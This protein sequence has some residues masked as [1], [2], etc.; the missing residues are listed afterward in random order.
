MAD[1]PMTDER[2]AEIRARLVTLNP[3]V[4]E[5]DAGFTSHIWNGSEIIAADVLERNAPFLV[6]APDDM[7]TLLAEV[8]RLRT[9]ESVLQD[10][11]NGL[12][13]GMMLSLEPGLPTLIAENEAAMRIV[14]E[15]AAKGVTIYS[16]DG[17]PE[18]SIAPE[19]IDKARAL[20]AQE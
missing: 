10:E 20:L 6:H 18:A 8:D 15:V 7:R 11:V 14:R 12:R 19:T 2:L 9:R 16:S 1:E 3:G 4:W 13:H 17:K 5:Y